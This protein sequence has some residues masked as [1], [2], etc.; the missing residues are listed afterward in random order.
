MTQDRD[1]ELEAARMEIEKLRSENEELKKSGASTGR[2][3]WVR[4][5]AV[6]V[7]FV[8]GALLVPTAGIAVWSRNTILDTDRYVETVA[9]LSNEPAVI[10]SV[11]TRITNAIFERVDVQTELQ[12]YLPPRLTFAAG[13]IADQVESTTQGLIVKALESDQFDTLWREINRTASTA[14]VAYVNSEGSSALTIENGQLFL[15]LGPVLDSVKQTLTDQGFSLAAKIPS[16]TA[17]VRLPVGDV[18]AIQQ[19]KSTLHLL[20]VLAYVLP[21]L[22]LLCFIG[23]V[24]L[25]RDRRRGVVIV[26]VIV[27]GAALLLG[28]GIAVGREGYLN[29]AT[30]GGANPETAAV[31]FDTLIR[32]LR[33]GIRVF[34]LIG[35]LLAIGAVIT[36]PSTWAVRTRKTIGSLITSGG[37]RT[38]W[39]SGAFGSFFARHRFGLMGAAVVVMAI[40]L[41]TLSPPTPGSVLW[42]TLGLLVL[43][44]VIQFIAATAPREAVESDGSTEDGGTDQQDTKEISV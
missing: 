12:Q 26:G 17:Q 38:G 9:P 39:D 20:N 1:Q 42:L 11:A 10:D 28:V 33:N 13:P 24:L 35:V 7:L 25:M 36:G 32:F 21:L 40:W 18:S 5:T 22:A 16:T 3:N 19:L 30:D 29:A 44:V 37:E 4:S 31:L 8:L 41:F 15:D 6:V 14:L 23:A 2:G 43:L 34:F 27:A